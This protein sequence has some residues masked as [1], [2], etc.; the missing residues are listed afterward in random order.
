LCVGYGDPYYRTFE[1]NFLNVG[2]SCSF[3]VLQNNCAG[4]ARVGT[5]ITFFNRLAFSQFKVVANH[6][7]DGS[8]TWIK[9]VNVLFEG[10]NYLI[11]NKIRVNGRAIELPYRHE[12]VRVFRRNRYIVVDTPL[13]NVHF[14]G[15]HLIKVRSCAPSFCG[16]CGNSNNTPFKQNQ[17]L[18]REKNRP[19]CN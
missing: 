13:F 19:G 1:G 16:V 14:D 5:P 11:T 15:D 8:R 7:R 3:V 12:N 2:P 17:Y 10:N 4:S 6:Q 18:I 9:S